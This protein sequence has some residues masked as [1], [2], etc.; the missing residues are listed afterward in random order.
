MTGL[1]QYGGLVKAVAIDLGIQTKTVDTYYARAK[2]KI[3]SHTRTAALL[4][5]DRWSQGKH[6][7]LQTCD[8]CKGTGLVRVPLCA[9]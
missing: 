2:E 5:W 4:E 6:G 1:V 3:G 7:A 9:V 8:H